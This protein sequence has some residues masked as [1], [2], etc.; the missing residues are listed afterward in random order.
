MFLHDCKLQRPYVQLLATILLLQQLLCL[1]ACVFIERNNKQMGHLAWT[2]NFGTV[3]LVCV[4]V[5]S[6]STESL[7]LVAVTLVV[8]AI[9]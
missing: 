2:F 3:A 9:T 8:F 6:L 7:S 4:R 1:S 5:L